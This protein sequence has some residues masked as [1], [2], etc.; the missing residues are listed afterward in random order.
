MHGDA[1]TWASP[2]LQKISDHENALDSKKDKF[3]YAFNGKWTEF[4]AQFQH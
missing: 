3:P 4:V 1:A 2:H